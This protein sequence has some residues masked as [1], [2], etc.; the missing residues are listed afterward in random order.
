MP[1]APQ[2]CPGSQLPQSILPPQPSPTTPQYW[3]VACVQ[4]VGE[5]AP[6]SDDAP[7]TF[8]MPPPPQVNGE[9][10]APQS[11]KRPQPSPMAPQ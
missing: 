2:D 8:E 7:H 9:G 10:H 6:E 5:Q 11:S 1:A 4:L 3:P